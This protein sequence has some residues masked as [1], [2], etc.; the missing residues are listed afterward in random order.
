MINPV[1]EIFSDIP[2]P[3]QEITITSLLEPRPESEEVKK[4][5]SKQKSRVKSKVPDTSSSVPPQFKCRV[6]DCKASVSFVMV[7]V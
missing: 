3:S 6:Q 2:V 4:S 5:L 1:T 7:M